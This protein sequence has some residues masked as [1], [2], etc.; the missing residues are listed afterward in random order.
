MIH[1][2][3]QTSCTSNVDIKKDK[4]KSYLS[5]LKV[6]PSLN[7]PFFQNTEYALQ[8]AFIAAVIAKFTVGFDD[9]R[10]GAVRF[11]SGASVRF[12]LDT[13]YDKDEMLNDVNS[14]RQESE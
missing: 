1:K 10:F 14:W 2:M 13:F 4:T 8:S 6:G 9:V 12:Y 7:L 11:S 5:R 3:P